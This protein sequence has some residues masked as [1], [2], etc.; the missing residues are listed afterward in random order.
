M[1]SNEPLQYLILT[2]YFYLDQYGIL[3]RVH[4]I[5]T[6]QDMNTSRKYNY[7]WIFD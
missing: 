7:L 3:C 1:T 6:G 4:S 5:V 2:P